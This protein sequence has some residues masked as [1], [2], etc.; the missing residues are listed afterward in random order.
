MLTLLLSTYNR[1]DVLA[2]TLDSFTELAPPEDGW[3]VVIVDNRS[4][5]NTREVALS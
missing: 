3:K 5:D 2:K 4:D 1:S